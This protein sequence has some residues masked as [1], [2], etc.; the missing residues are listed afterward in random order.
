MRGVGVRVGVAAGDCG[1]LVGDRRG[2]AVAAGAVLV[3]RG[4]GVAVAGGGVLVGTLVAGRTVGPDEGTGGGVLIGGSDVGGGLP[5]VG[6]GV[7]ISC[8]VA[9]TMGD[10][11]VSRGDNRNQSNTRPKRAKSNRSGPLNE[12]IRAGIGLSLR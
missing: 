1:V 5:V 11:R 8:P 7:P 6:W 3:D 10:A 9:R 2:V 4:R 12:R